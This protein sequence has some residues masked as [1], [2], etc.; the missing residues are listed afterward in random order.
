MSSLGDTILVELGLH[1]GFEAAKSA[2]DEL[3]IDKPLNKIIPVHEANLST[4]AVKV[5]TITLKYRHSVEDAKL[6]FFR[7]STHADPSL[8]ASVGDYLSVEKGWF[9]PYLFASARRPGIP[10]TMKPDVVFCHGPFL[11]GDYKIGET[12]VKQSANVLQ[13]CEAPPPP[14]TEEECSSA[15]TA[16]TQTNW[17]ISGIKEKVNASNSKM[18]GKL[19]KLIHRTNLKAQPSSS[20]ADSTERSTSPPPTLQ[21][22]V[23]PPR[24]LAV[25]LL[26]I[27]PHRLGMWTSSARPSESVLQYILLNGSPTIILPALAGSPLLAWNTLTLKQ[28]HAKRDKYDG[29][30]RILFEYISLCVDW[31]RVTVGDGDED[32]KKAVRDAVELVVAAAA[33]SW[34]SKAV[35]KEVDL[36]RAGIV[37][38]RIL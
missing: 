9:S 15:T 35:L 22:T 18:N 23:P 36:E 6:G 4:S 21:P 34:D 25:V 27:K 17:S 7:S 12:L 37:V 11:D 32:R 1:V 10:R 24:R 14:P 13:L 5:L 30:V 26:G 8:F 2:A 3:L 29:I 33:Q 38:F 19:T 28:I 31:E 16:T 20:D